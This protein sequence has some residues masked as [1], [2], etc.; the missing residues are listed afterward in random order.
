MK[1][2][3]VRTLVD[4]VHGHRDDLTIGVTFAA[5]W[6]AEDEDLI[7]AVRKRHSRHQGSEV[8]VA[9]VVAGEDRGI[10]AGAKVEMLIGI[11]VGSGPNTALRVGVAVIVAVKVYCGPDNVFAAGNV[12]PTR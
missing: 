7:L 10:I 1:T 12:R 2:H 5:P 9:T 4:G 6:G 3:N 8:L 11:R